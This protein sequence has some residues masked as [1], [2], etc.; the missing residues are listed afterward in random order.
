MSDEPDTTTTDDPAVVTTA[1][2]PDT[3]TVAEGGEDWTE[4]GEIAGDLH[5]P[6]S[7]EVPTSDSEEEETGAPSEPDEA[8]LPAEEKAPAGEEAEIDPILLR[9]VQEELAIDAERAKAIGATAL[10]DMLA[11]FDQRVT[12]AGG[13]PIGQPPMPGQPPPGHQPIPEIAKFDLK[14]DAEEVPD[15]VRQ[16]LQAMNEHYAQQQQAMEQRWRQ[17]QEDNLQVQQ[18]R[19]LREDLVVFDGVLEAE[20]A[21]L[22]HL[23]GKGPSLSL[24]PN[25]LFAANRR[26]VF[27][28]ACAIQAQRA[29]RGLPPLD[30]REVSARALHATYRDHF[31][32]LERQK[33]AAE[34]KEHAKRRSVAPQTKRRTGADTDA[35]ID[36]RINARIEHYEKTGEVLTDPPR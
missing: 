1:N 12:G 10:R 28:Q 20:A 2:T 6:E 17:Q 11:N 35:E 21:G 24:P 5:R 23:L 36:A 30:R 15:S 4:L 25:S 19:Q 13:M 32:E 22:E 14:L 8:K 31:R 29:S 3:E 34:A 27:D 9:Q 33:I 26:A 18:Q 7:T 16:Q